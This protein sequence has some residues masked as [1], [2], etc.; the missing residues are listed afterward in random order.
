MGLSMTESLYT[1]KKRSTPYGST[2]P[3]RSTIAFHITFPGKD[4]ICISCL[5][6]FIRRDRF[7]WQLIL[8]V[9]MS[10]VKGSNTH[11]V[12]IL[13]GV[14]IC[15][16]KPVKVKDKKIILEGQCRLHGFKERDAVL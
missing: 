7:T 6:L 16:L 1:C 15:V 3:P 10:G 14:L 12:N 4:P 2:W 5:L 9:S 8:L 13:L 11:T